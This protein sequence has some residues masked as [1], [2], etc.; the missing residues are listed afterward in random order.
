M[1]VPNTTT[2]SLLDV[3][4]EIAGGPTSLQAC[5]DNA[6]A[7]AFDPA[8]SGSK[9]SLLNF[10][11][12]N[13]LTKIYYQLYQCVAPNNTAYTLLAPPLASQRYADANGGM[14]YR[15]TNTYLQQTTNP[16]GYISTMQIVSGQT[17]CP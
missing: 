5:F 1:A 16:G 10:R 15:Y 9:N 7:S 14:I 13:N 2:F 12:Y 6:I 8:Y 11:N 17:G 4:A 3:V